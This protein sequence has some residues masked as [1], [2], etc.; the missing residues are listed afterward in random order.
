MNV[1]AVLIVLGFFTLVFALFYMQKRQNLAMIEKNMNPREYANRPAPYRNLKWGLLLIGAGL[2]L[3][4]AYL[5]DQFGIPSRDNEIIY[6]ALVAIGGGIGLVGSYRVE[7]KE[8][9]DRRSEI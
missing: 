7:K 3:F 5:I 6:F 9:L 2:G 8:L 4:I 1:T